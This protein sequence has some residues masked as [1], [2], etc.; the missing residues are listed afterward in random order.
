ML[1][2]DHVRSFAVFTYFC[3]DLFIID[4]AIIGFSTGDGLYASRNATDCSY[5]ASEWVN[6]VYELTIP[7]K[8]SVMTS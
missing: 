2:T 1:V 6:I 5:Y 4:D 3:D 8:F 7:G